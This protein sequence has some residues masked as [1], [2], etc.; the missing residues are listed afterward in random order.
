MTAKTL[1]STEST[2]AQLLNAAEELFVQHGLD[3]VS[4]RAILREAGQRNQSALQYHFGSREG[5]ITAI[6]DR[7]LLQLETRRSALVDEAVAL[8][9]RP[10]LRECCALLARAPFLLCREDQGFRD[11]LGLFGQQLL[12][13]NLAI[14]SFV[15]EQR[16]P[17]LTIVWA[18]LLGHLA[19]LEP[20]L[21]KLRI[22]NT[23][24]MALLAISGRARRKESF[25]GAGAE[26]FFNN[27]V[28]QI[29]AMLDATVSAETLAL[30]DSKKP[31]RTHSS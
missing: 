7:R 21:L 1:T 12:I 17:S 14:S 19:P 24:G 4:L 13:S 9:P 6:V 23:F 28:D 3:D 30:V 31:A 5:L 11:F 2:R 25:R 8:N 22:E 20:A 26:L 10:E 27:L 15:E 18:T 16:T 29:A